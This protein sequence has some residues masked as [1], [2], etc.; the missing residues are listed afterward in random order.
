VAGESRIPDAA[1]PPLPQ[2]FR[3]S[4]RS[5]A[6]TIRR[7]MAAVICVRCAKRVQRAV[8]LAEGWVCMRCLR[9]ERR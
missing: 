4:G 8:K 9:A 3:G 1:S 6:P 7:D 2:S 5:G